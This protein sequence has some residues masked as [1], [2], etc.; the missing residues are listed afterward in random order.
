LPPAEQSNS[1]GPPVIIISPPLFNPPHVPYALS[2]V[3]EMD[4]EQTGNWISTL[5]W[6]K[7]WKEAE[8]YARKFR[9]NSITG[10][11]L[12]DLDSEMLKGNLGMTDGNHRVELLNTIQQLYQKCP[13]HH[14]SSV[15]SVPLSLNTTANVTFGCQSEVL[16]NYSLPS[17]G[18]DCITI[19]NDYLV[20]PGSTQTHLESD[21]ESGCSRCNFSTCSTDG[22][23][24]VQMD[25]TPAF[26]SSYSKPTGA[27]VSPYPE[28]QR[29]YAEVLAD[30]KVRRSRPEH[31]RS[32]AEALVGPSKDRLSMPGMTRRKSVEQPKKM[33][34]VVMSEKREDTASIRSTRRARYR[35]LILTLRPDQMSQDEN[36]IRRRL[37]HF[38]LKVVSVN[39]LQGSDCRYLLI[40]PHSEMAQQA[41]HKADDLD[42]ELTKKW[43]ERPNP[44]RPIK[45][46]SMRW[47]LIREGK[48]FSG[49]IIGKLG[50]GEIVTVNQ[51]K[52]RRARL[53]DVCDGELK[54]R[55]WVSVH[56]AEGEPLLRQ[57]SEIE[58]ESSSQTL[59]TRVEIYPPE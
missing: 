6:Y 51:V 48:A 36:V 39:L 53:I 8:T 59:T 4:V 14:T 25:L 24:P 22:V 7:G 45:Y 37:E 28:Q 5:A 33:E 43:P 27:E 11:S 35:K 13:T 38:E 18:Y 16:N 52:G 50:A 46:I 12:Q 44:K 41:F 58:R 56:T 1:Y 21:S 29:S 15:C 9:E 31:Q 3:D 10:K 2:R 55:G 30:T 34:D 19:L 47:L 54:T 57:L 42:Y 40:F 17:A 49:K 32:Y 20:P 23:G 26:D